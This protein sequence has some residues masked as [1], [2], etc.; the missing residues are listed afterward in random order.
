M[1]AIIAMI[2]TWDILGWYHDLILGREKYIIQK[3]SSERIYFLL[4]A[5]PLKV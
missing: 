2:E 3:N 4:N 1:I 5:L